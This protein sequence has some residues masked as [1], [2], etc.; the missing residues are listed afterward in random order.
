MRR[1]ER[2]AKIAA[3]Q[4]K[5]QWLTNENNK[6]EAECAKLWQELI[7]RVGKEEAMNLYNN[8]LQHN[9]EDNKWTHAA[10]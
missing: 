5:I 4:A 1:A 9:S 3:L 7:D 10:L 8:V 2:E 6:L